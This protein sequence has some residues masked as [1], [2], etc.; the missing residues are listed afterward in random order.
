LI[1]GV[2]AIPGLRV[3]GQPD[4]CLFAFTSDKLN[5][6]Q[7]GDC[8]AAKGWTI[9]PQFGKPGAPTN[10]H[11]S[12]H[13]GTVGREDEFLAAL[14]QSVEEVK[15]LPPIDAAA[16]KA[17]LD[18]LLASNDPHLF[19]KA[20]AMAGIQGDALPESMALINTLLESMPD[21]LQAHFLVEYFNNLYS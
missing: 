14:R 13:Y 1:A 19:E 10:L 17:G 9:Q 4:M 11:I 16:I 21:E 5:V 20:A 8:M 18:D 15:C 3:M 7:L 2:N 12:V 6:F